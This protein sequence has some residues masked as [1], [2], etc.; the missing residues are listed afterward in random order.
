MRDAGARHRPC[1]LRRGVRRNLNSDCAFLE[2]T[3][4][5]RNATGPGGPTHLDASRHRGLSKSIIAS[6]PS[7][8]RPARGV[9]GL[10]R[11]AP[12]GRAVS[13]CLRYRRRTYPP[14]RAQTAPGK[15]GHAGNHR[16][17]GP[18]TRGR[19]AGT[20]RLGPP[21]GY[22]CRIS[23]IPFPATAPRPASGDADQTPLVSK[24][25]D[26]RTISIG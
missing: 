12:G 17:W 10:L 25:R 15:S 2:K 6:P 21:G 20:E 19:R 11:S 22:R 18:V 24:G 26:A 23:D 14:L 1:F 9:L 7:P 4:G 8:W 5:A 16:Q 3:E 13:G